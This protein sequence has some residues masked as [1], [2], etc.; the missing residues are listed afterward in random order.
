M[1]TECKYQNR[2]R[3]IKSEGKITTKESHEHAR[4]HTNTLSCKTYTH[5]LIISGAKETKFLNPS[6]GNSFEVV[7][8][9][10]TLTH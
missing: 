9:I 10:S 5:L 7:P 6:P 1:L 8:Q 4:A 3:P 2:A